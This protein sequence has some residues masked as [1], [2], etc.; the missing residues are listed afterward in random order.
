M[1]PEYVA[2]R[3]EFL[4]PD[5]H[6]PPL[7]SKVLLLTPGGTCVIGH[8]SDWFVGWHP[9]PRVPASLRASRA[10]QRST[11]PSDGSTASETGGCGA[12]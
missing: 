8:W 11:T 5:E 3:A 1:T 7:G 12:R 2:G 4:D 10:S 6:T 9:L